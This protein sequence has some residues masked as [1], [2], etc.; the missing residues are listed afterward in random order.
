MRFFSLIS[1]LMLA[2]ATL[3]M[4]GTAVKAFVIG[5]RRRAAA[6][7][8][9]WLGVLGI[10]G[11]I[12]VAVSLASHDH[13]LAPGQEKRFCA[14]DC[15]LAYSVTDVART[16]DAPRD[17]HTLNVRLRV[18]NDAKVEPVRPVNVHAWLVTDQDPRIE[19]ASISPVVFHELGPGQDETID[20][21]FEV[22]NRAKD[23]KLT[24]TE[25]GW[26]TR[27]VIGDENSFLHRK[28]MF[29]IEEPLNASAGSS[30]RP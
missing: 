8:G 3:A 25:G 16:N 9:A 29:R 22:P 24:V 14:L 7:F 11:V 18:R 28:T 27:F 17:R 5:R 15:D 19:P 2:V 6:T 30:S 12:L 13:V 26:P 10:Y 21:R 23:L 4:L 1:L 20:L